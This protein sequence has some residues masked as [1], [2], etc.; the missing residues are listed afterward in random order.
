M[1]AILPKLLCG[2]NIATPLPDERE[3]SHRRD[4]QSSSQHRENQPTKGERN[5]D[6]EDQSDCEYSEE[7][8]ASN[9]SDNE[10]PIDQSDYEDN[11]H[12]VA[13]DQSDIE[14][15]VVIDQSDYDGE[16]ATDQS[17]NDNGLASEQSDMEYKE[18]ELAANQSDLEDS[19]GDISIDQSDHEEGELS[20]RVKLGESDEEV[21]C[22]CDSDCPSDCD[23]FHHL[24][25][26]NCDCGFVQPDRDNDSPPGSEN[27]NTGRES[28]AECENPDT[29]R[30]YHT[31]C[32]T[33]TER[34]TVPAYKPF[35]KSQSDRQMVT[36]NNNVSH[37]K[38]SAQL[39]DMMGELRTAIQAVQVRRSASC[40][41]PQ[42][43]RESA[44]TATETAENYRKPDSKESEARRRERRLRLRTLEIKREHL[45]DEVRDGAEECV[46]ER[47]YSEKDSVDV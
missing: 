44:E 32:K 31:E 5:C 3:E 38:Y 43:Q 26:P 14:E 13:S 34:E 16:I 10:V 23:G 18:D 46:T 12:N 36:R 39:P 1:G 22:E 6:D 9:Q 33:R 2:F 17:D 4:S 29:G 11:V 24:C 7:E 28:H 45:L 8:V 15:E 40:R 21:L 37:R 20:E 41:E 30:E 42:R 27:P 19:E 25:G 47:I 35:I